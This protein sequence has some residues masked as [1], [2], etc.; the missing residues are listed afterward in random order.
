LR[1]MILHF[2]QMVFTDGLTFMVCS[3]F[4]NHCLLRQVM[5]PL[6]RS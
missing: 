1:L 4:R 3:S 5:R 2:S 6:V